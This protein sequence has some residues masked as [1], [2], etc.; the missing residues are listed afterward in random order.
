[1]TAPNKRPQP[2][3]SAPPVQASQGQKWSA[4]ERP[5]TCF[6][7]QKTIEP[8]FCV[9]TKVTKTDPKRSW[10]WWGKAQNRRVQS[11][12]GLHHVTATHPK[13]RRCGKTVQSKRGLHPTRGACCCFSSP[14]LRGRWIAK[15]DGGGTFALAPPRGFGT[16]QCVALLALKPSRNSWMPAQPRQDTLRLRVLTRLN[17]RA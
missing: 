13:F 5:L 4:A 16:V 7:W 11:P 9:T 14:R 17:W 6:N 15:R 12:L 8:R 2:R 1:M 10:Q 3:N